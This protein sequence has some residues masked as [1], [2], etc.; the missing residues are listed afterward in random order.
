MKPGA[1][2]FFVSAEQHERELTNAYCEGM[3]MGIGCAMFFALIVWLGI[4]A[5]P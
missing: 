2:P 4:Q 1:D 5:I 3:G